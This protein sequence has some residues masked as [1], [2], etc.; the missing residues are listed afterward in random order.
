MLATKMKTNRMRMM[1]MRMMMSMR[2]ICFDGCMKFSGFYCWSFIFKDEFT[3]PPGVQ[4]AQRC[5]EK[6]YMLQ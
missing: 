4:S 3:Y 1:R 6:G 5:L 2:M